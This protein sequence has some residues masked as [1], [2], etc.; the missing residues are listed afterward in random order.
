MMTYADVCCEALREEAH[1][2]RERFAA[3]PLLAELLAQR[4]ELG[5]EDTYIVV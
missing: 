5:A 4:R 3:Q 1:L 2:P